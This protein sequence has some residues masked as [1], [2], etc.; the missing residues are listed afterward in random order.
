LDDFRLWVPGR[1]NFEENAM[2]LVMPD[3]SGFGG[4][5]IPNEALG[6]EHHLE[7]PADIRQCFSV[8][9]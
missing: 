6:R 8:H 2:K 5:A 4:A 9:Y 7:Q 3:A 1:E